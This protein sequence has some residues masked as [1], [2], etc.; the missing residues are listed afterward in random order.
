MTKL[1]RKQRII[2]LCPHVSDC[3]I[4]LTSVFLKLSSLN[5]VRRC[6]RSPYT[7][8][9]IVF[10]IPFIVNKISLLASFIYGTIS[11]WPIRGFSTNISLL[12]YHHIGKHANMMPLD[13][14]ETEYVT[15]VRYPQSWR[16]YLGNREYLPSV[17]LSQIVLSAVTS[18]FLT[19]SSL[20]L[21]WRCNRSLDTPGQI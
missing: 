20:N 11:V 2:T 13:D 3:T 21:V 10:S 18:V 16:S 7:S 4:G 14:V 5:L 19:L 8:F 15:T 1:F 17:H 9:Q 12:L 6:K